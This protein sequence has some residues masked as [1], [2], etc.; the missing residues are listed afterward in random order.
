[1][2]TKE[3]LKGYFDAIHKG[4]WQSFIADDFV[5]SSSNLDKVVH[6]K[7]AYVERAGRFFSATTAVDVAQL[8]IDGDT[9]C[10]VARYR[11]RSPSGKTGVCDVAEILT[12]ED[13]KINSSAIFFDTKAFADFIAQG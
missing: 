3:I 6:G 12:V 9:A 13:G 8:V 7:A 4:G 10:A 1:M 11:L 5:F 2:S